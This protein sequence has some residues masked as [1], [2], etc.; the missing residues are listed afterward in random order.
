MPITERSA[1]SP[2]ACLVV[3]RLTEGA[4]GRGGAQEPTFRRRLASSKSPNAHRLPRGGRA[5]QILQEPPQ[6]ESPKG[7]NRALTPSMLK[8]VRRADKGQKGSDEIVVAPKASGASTPCGLAK[9][10]SM[11][12]LTCGLA[13][14][15]PR[16]GLHG[17]LVRS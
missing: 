6:D 12:L 13:G 5:Q 11:C 8:A 4:R 17:M 7:L 10:L 9:G 14:F 3:G 15:P 1:R 2:G 16:K